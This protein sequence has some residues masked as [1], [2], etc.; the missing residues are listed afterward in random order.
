MAILVY[1]AATSVIWVL[2]VVRV[3]SINLKLAD[4]FAS[5]YPEAWQ[6]VI[7]E[8]S[9]QGRGN[10]WLHAHLWQYIKTKPLSDDKVIKHAKRQRENW[11]SFALG[12]PVLIAMVTGFLS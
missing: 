11:I 8:A 3:R 12:G 1:L 7:T 2:T 10:G 5:S 9:L 6:K 4:Y